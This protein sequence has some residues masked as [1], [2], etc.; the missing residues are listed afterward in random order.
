MDNNKTTKTNSLLSYEGCTAKAQEIRASFAD[1]AKGE[2][3]E[4]DAHRVLRIGE[5][6]ARVYDQ[7]AARC[8]NAMY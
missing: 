2:R 7:Q 4:E 1:I 6:L 5:A 3:T 8:I